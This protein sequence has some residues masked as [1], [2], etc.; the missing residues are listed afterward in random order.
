MPGRS[1]RAVQSRWDV[2][3]SRRVI[4]RFLGGTQ[5]TDLQGHRPLLGHRRGCRARCPV[6]C[7]G[8]PAAKSSLEEPPGLGRKQGAAWHRV[9][10]SER[11]SSEWQGCSC[12]RQG[13][14]TGRWEEPLPQQDSIPR[15]RSHTHRAAGPGEGFWLQSPG[16]HCGRKRPLTA[17]CS[18]RPPG[19]LLRTQSWGAAEGPLGPFV[20]DRRYRW[21]P[22]LPGGRAFGAAE[23]VAV[24]AEGLPGQ[25][26]VR[27]PSPGCPQVFP[28]PGPYLEHP[29]PQ[30]SPRVLR[31]C[32]IAGRGAYSA[33]TPTPGRGALEPQID[34]PALT[35]AQLPRL[36]PGP[37]L[38]CP[39][40]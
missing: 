21:R 29:G 11:L 19:R 14:P 17:I 38:P 39:R 7:L 28:I 32:R 36:C 34:T 35:P 31:S 26:L 3:P 22:R 18:T 10:R 8:P 25:R 23:R 1:G 33:L 15:P 13:A 20:P 4:D 6:S 40:L 5:F 27:G 9:G 12:S 30:S 2:R 37:L 24:G 16:P